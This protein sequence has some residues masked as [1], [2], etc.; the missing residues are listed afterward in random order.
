MPTMGDVNV[1]TMTVVLTWMGQA[2]QQQDKGIQFYPT[3]GVSPVDNA[4]NEIVEEFL[5]SDCTHLMMIDADTIPPMD[6][7]DKLLAHD[8][9][10]VTALTPIIEHDAK[11][12]ND[13]NGFY[14]KYNAVGWDDQFLQANV[15]LQKIRGCG[16]SCILIKRNVLEKMEDPWF[17]FTYK[18]DTGKKT[19]IGE[20]V[21]FIMMSIGKGFVPMADTSIICGH[22]KPIIW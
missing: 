9:D 4:R 8:L 13:S 7:L 11:R 15:G 17:R 18:D 6:A 21:Y 20:D 14:K 22:K 2:M 12:I 5:K 10:I 16:A 3:M 19:F 1:L